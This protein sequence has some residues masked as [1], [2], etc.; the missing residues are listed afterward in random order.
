[1]AP[2]CWPTSLE[3]L[4]GSLRLAI[5]GFLETLG[6]PEPN[7]QKTL[8]DPWDSGAKLS[9]E[10]PVLLIHIHVLVRLKCSG[11][12]SKD[13]LGSMSPAFLYS[14]YFPTLSIL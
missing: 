9:S 2:A 13:L 6:Q 5:K 3:H 10:T 12:E 11:R 7:L 1:M 8:R 14:K 4:R